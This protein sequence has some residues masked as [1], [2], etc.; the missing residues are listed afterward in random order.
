MPV[1]WPDLGP[2]PTKISLRE[3][4]ENLKLLR[5]H[6]DVDGIYERVRA[7]LKPLGTFQKGNVSAQH[8][9]AIK[10]RAAADRIEV[11]EITNR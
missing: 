5:R 4:V 1:I 3:Q 10:G 7:G 8:L 9:N 6:N 2:L 11:V